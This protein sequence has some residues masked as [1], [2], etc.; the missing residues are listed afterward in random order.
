MI[1]T[2]LAQGPL[3]QLRSGLGIG[4]IGYLVIFAWILGMIMLAPQQYLLV[5]AVLCIL[6]AV[7]L[8][9][10]NPRRLF[11]WRWLL[12][13]LLLSLPPVFFLG[14]LDQTFLG[15]DYSSEG[16]GTEIQIA[17]RFIVV[18]IAINGLT[19]SVEITAIAAILERF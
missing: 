3:A 13:M 19:G 7:I 15:M 14:E 10:L 16:L 17:L 8:F 6:V 12:F 2:G 4:S 18:L 11:H 5:V 9:P 1:K